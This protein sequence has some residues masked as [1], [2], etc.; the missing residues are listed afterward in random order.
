[1]YALLTTVDLASAL[2][3]ASD[4]NIADSGINLLKKLLDNEGVFLY[5]SD[6]LQAFILLCLIIDD[7]LLQLA[8]P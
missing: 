6:L 3:S 2:I 1:M 8:E 7:S 5:Q 4:F